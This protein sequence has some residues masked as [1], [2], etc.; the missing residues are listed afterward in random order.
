MEI[1]GGVKIGGLGRMGC[2]CEG[3]LVAKGF[4][5]ACVE[6]MIV[7]TSGSEEDRMDDSETNKRLSDIFC[8]FLGQLALLYVPQF[9]VRIRFNP[10][11]A[12]ED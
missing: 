11:R 8:T 7:N 6:V 2:F 5:D 10:S 4:E 9:P 3:W 1:S 12:G